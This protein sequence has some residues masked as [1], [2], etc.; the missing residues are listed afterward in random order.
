M[1]GA[2]LAV[3]LVAVA[4]CSSGGEEGGPGRRAAEAPAAAVAGPTAAP[5]ETYLKGQLH[6]HSAASGDSDT[7]AA[8]RAT[9]VPGIHPVYR[10][11]AD[12]GPG[13]AD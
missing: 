6:L 4:S 12:G 11:S 2:R 3:L 9:T 13:H 7:P 5:R 8:A 1:L 10:P